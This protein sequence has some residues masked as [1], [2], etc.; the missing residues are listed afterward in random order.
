MV[1]EEITLTDGTGLLSAE[2]FN[3]GDTVQQTFNSLLAAIQT[4]ALVGI[5]L[6]NTAFAFASN[7][8]SSTSRGL[9]GS[10]YSPR[11][12]AKKTL[13]EGHGYNTGADVFRYRDAVAVA[14]D[15]DDTVRIVVSVGTITGTVHIE[16]YY[17]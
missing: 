2:L 9:G 12:A 13:T 17:N 16:W 1:S 3:T 10:V 15:D 14:T 5:G 4:A 11:D 8:S 6:G 7:T